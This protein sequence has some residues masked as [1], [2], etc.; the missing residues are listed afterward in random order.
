[1]PAAGGAPMRRRP[2]YFLLP[3]CVVAEEIPH[4]VLS[5]PT[6]GVLVVLCGNVGELIADAVILAREDLEAR[7]FALRDHAPE[8]AAARQSPMTAYC[9]ISG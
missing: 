3:L 4:L 2:F 7:A 6:T 9:P 1:M 5:E 8:R